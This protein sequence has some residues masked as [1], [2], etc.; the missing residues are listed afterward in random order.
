MSTFFSVMEE[1]NQRI[2]EVLIA[3]VRPFEF[4]MGKVLGGLAVALT[5]SSVYIIGGAATIT[6]MGMAEYLP[7]HLLPWF[8]V[9]MLLAIIMFGSNFAAVGSACS[10]AK[11]AQ[12]LTLPAMLPVMVPMFLL[13]P[14][15]KHPTG[16]FATVLSLLPPFT[17][18]LMM[19]R[20]SSSMTIPAWQPWVGLAGIVVFTLL[21][22]WA[23]GRIFRVAILTQGKPPR[24]TTLLKWAIRG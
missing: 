24:L 9:Y 15:L 1:K 21:S 13:G 7:Y 20:Q 14:I 18:T 8:F 6:R 23:G 3:S 22:V 12:T 2:A 10:D 16:P 19:M 5:A 17:P 11:D 4:M